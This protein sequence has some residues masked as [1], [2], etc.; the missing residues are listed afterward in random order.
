MFN[1]NSDSG[2]ETIGKLAFDITNSAVSNRTAQASRLQ[3]VSLTPTNFGPNSFQAPSFSSTPYLY[4][5][6]DT[7]AISEAVNRSRS[8]KPSNNLNDRW[9]LRRRPDQ[10]PTMQAASAA[11]SAPALFPNPVNNDASPPAFSARPISMADVTAAVKPFT[12]REQ[13]DYWL[14]QFNRFLNYRK[15]V[16]QDRIDLFTLLMQGAA[17]DWLSTLPPATLATETVLF[18]EFKNRFGLSPAQKMRTERE[19]WSRDQLDSETVDEYVTT[20]QVIANRIGMSHENLLR[21]IIQGLKPEL[22]LF[23]MN[24]DVKTIKEL[25]SVARMCEAARGVDKQSPT[26][27][28]A[29]LTEVVGSLA[30]KIEKLVDKPPAVQAAIEAQPPGGGSRNRRPAGRRQPTGPSQ[31]NHQGPPQRQWTPSPQ[32]FSAAPISQ[33]PQPQWRQTGQQSSSSMQQLRHDSSHWRHLAY[34]PLHGFNQQSGYLSNCC[35]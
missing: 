13:V 4:P 8:T 28:I 27:S 26:S 21:M 1:S 7:D 12:G 33:G 20:M 34:T 14:G 30:L 9:F 25:L 5:N 18:T 35:H 3:Q 15:V 16:G 11:P 31:W 24:A 2:E 6:S 29:V 19:L 22:R 23:T 17:R 10:D 32:Q